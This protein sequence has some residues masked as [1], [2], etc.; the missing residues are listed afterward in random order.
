MALL[1][2]LAKQTNRRYDITRALLLAG[3]F[4]IIQNP[5]ILVFDLSFQL[6]FL[7]TMALIWVA[8]LVERKVQFITPKYKLR[9][10]VVSTI[11][12]QIFVL[13]FIIYKMGLLSIF[14]LFANVLILPAIP[15]IMFLGFSVG[16][17]GFISTVLTVPVSFVCTLLLTYVL[18]IIYLF[19]HL[20][21]S[22][23][24]IESFPLVLVIIIYLL[25]FIIIW[26][27]RKNETA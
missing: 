6:S 2:L 21:F 12:T 8:P 15:I 24:T 16:F 11:A 13:P 19:S 23:V 1:V 22:S 14:A 3:V 9:E 25:L 7:A 17:L 5:K 10:L 18:K 26:Q 4:M 20:P 27:S